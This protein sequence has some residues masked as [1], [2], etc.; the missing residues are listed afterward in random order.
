MLD[1]CLY[2]DVFLIWSLTSKSTFQMSLLISASVYNCKLFLVLLQPP[3]P[4]HHP[5]LSAHLCRCQCRTTD[6][7]LWSFQPS[8]LDKGRFPEFMHNPNLAYCSTPGCI[9]CMITRERTN[10][11]S[12]LIYCDV[13]WPMADQTGTPCCLWEAKLYGARVEES[14][15]ATQRSA[16]AFCLSVCLLVVGVTACTFHSTTPP[17]TSCPLVS[18]YWKVNATDLILFCA[19][20]WKYGTYC[21]ILKS[22]FIVH[23]QDYRFHT[24]VTGWAPPPTP[25]PV[26]IRRA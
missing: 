6:W 24:V 20:A 5:P 25:S 15:N 19:T 12:H 3:Q 23:D 1:Y 13:W 9:I 17:I 4:P 26:A 7:P 8:A 2:R 21:S 10:F 11:G 22:A 18:V 14:L 16:W